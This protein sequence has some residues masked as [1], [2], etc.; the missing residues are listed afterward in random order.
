MFVPFPFVITVGC[1][2]I[3]CWNKSGREIH[4]LIR[5]L[6][7]Y[8]ASWCYLKD[9]DEELNI[10]IYEAKFISDCHSYEVGKLFSTKKEIKIAI[11]DGYIQLLSLQFPGKKRMLA[12]ELL[13]GVSFSEVAKVH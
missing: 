6:S 12:S 13:N 1:Q 9:Q 5:G 11:K 8:P 7:P 3:E 4:N 2:F 10:K